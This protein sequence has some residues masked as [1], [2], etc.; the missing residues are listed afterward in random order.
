MQRTATVIGSGPNGLSAGVVL[1]QAGLK[2][3]L[4]EAALQI[5]GAASSGELT[6]P[7]FIH[8]RG[9]AVYP[10]GI[11]S[12]FFNKL[13]LAQHGLEWIQPPA[14]VAHP[15][16]DGTA[17][18]LERD[19][20]V[21]AAQFGDDAA[22]YRELFS[23]IVEQW[24]TLFDEVFRPLRV[25]HHPLLM[26][27]FGWRAIQP[28]T[29]LA[30]NMLGKARA[31]ALFGGIAA[32]SSLNLRAPMSAGF[33]LLLSA[34]GHAV[35]WPIPKG[36]AQRISNALAAVFESQG[37][38]ITTSSR[39]ADLQQIHARDL[40]LC[41]VTPRQFV[42]IAGHALPDPYRESLEQ[43]R[44][45]PGVFKMDWA[46]SEPIPWKAKD[47]LRAATVHLGGSIEELAE[48]ESAAWYGEPPQR[49][50]VLLVQPTLFD[51]TRAPA[52]RHTAWAYCH[53]PNGWHGSA[54]AQIEAQV[55]RFAPGFRECILARASHAPF[56][57]QQWNE[58]LVGGD[59][60]GGVTDALQFALRPSWRRYRTPL[61]GVYLCS[62]STPPGGSVHG[63]CGYYGA[64]WA[65]SDLKRR[66]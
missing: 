30:R 12:P 32:H 61:R 44:Y 3:G 17:V 13:P 36:G 39:I 1:A 10:M 49:P 19:V 38:R 33:G 56:Q 60:V 7:G 21:T 26:A 8:D 55:E 4:H 15:L 41:D 43:Y 6:L 11:S 34:A 51:P 59:I 65:L 2:V 47:C 46:L 63:L 66:R 62:S 57:M 64:R 20:N 45:G 53:V 40:I 29:V 28:A 25:P 58:N 37:G 14:A 23:P 24:P 48:S 35:G 22:R 54:V 27:R 31:Q 18:M 5:G 16:D 50:F 42:A 9:S 52:G